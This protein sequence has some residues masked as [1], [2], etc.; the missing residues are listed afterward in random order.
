M[1]SSRHGAR[2]DEHPD[3][4]AVLARV[5]PDTLRH[6]ARHGWA[7]PRRSS[8]ALCSVSAAASSPRCSPGQGRSPDRSTGPVRSHQRLHSADCCSSQMGLTVTS[9]VVGRQPSGSCASRRTTLPRGVPSQPQRRHHRSGS[10][11]RYASTAPPGS[12]RCPVTSKP[13]SSRAG[14][15]GQARTGEARPLGSAN[16][17]EVFWGSPH[18]TD[19]RSS[20]LCHLGVE[21]L[22]PYRAD[23]PDRGVASASVVAVF[24]PGADGEL[25][26]GLGRPAGRDVGS[27]PF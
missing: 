16:H 3:E 5:A 13:R 11:T 21:L 26:F 20:G 15:Q 25:G 14:E 19:T 9:C 22:E 23:H 24:D 8:A 1:L 7:P 2:G 18:L 6:Y 10:T 4:A 17:V 27:H 12:S